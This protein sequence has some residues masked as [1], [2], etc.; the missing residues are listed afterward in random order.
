MS[1]PF[2]NAIRGTTSG[3]PGTGAFTPNAAASGFVAWSTVPS[4]WIGL[5]RY[6]DGSNWELSYGYWNATTI[7]RPAAGFVSSSSGSQ[8]SLTSAATAS[9]VADG[10]GVNPHF[11]T[12]L[13]GARPNINNAGVTVIGLAAGTATGTAAA[14]SLATTNLL[15]L[16]PRVQYTSVTTANG[17]AGY[18]HAVTGGVGIPSTTAGRGGYEFAC[19]FGASGL[20]TGPRLFVGMTATNFV[21]NTAEPSA[22]TANCAFHGFDSTDSNIIQLITNS[23]AGTGTKI[24]TGITFAANGW[25]ESR[26]WTLPGSTTT[27]ARLFRFDTGDIHYT[28]TSTDVPA[29]GATMSPHC[30]GGLSATTGT[31]FVMQFGGYWV[32]TG[33]L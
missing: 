9:L 30:I 13:C 23:N 27:Y 29:S 11:V 31:A 18:T 19:R 5:V 16:Q 32:R 4:G 15:T 33:G 6:E 2:Y 21:G 3:A 25:Y 14:A 20:P 17:Q 28:S 8:L 10:D 12:P 26:I 22:L 7:T 24:S 1:G